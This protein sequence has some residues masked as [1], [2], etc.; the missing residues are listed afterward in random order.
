MAPLLQAIWS[1]TPLDVIGVII[2]QTNDISTLHKWCLATARSQLCGLTY[3]QRYR[4]VT[5]NLA[6]LPV[7]P[8]LIV[9]Q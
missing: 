5:I 7:D 1:Q 4:R 2:E 9:D 3:R 8:S 6:N